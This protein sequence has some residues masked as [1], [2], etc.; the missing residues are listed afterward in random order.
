[1]EEIF[2]CL[3][4]PPIS[5]LKEGTELWFLDVVKGNIVVC[6]DTV[7]S[8]CVVSDIESNRHKESVVEYRIKNHTDRLIRSDEIGERYFLSRC[9]LSQVLGELV[10][11]TDP[12]ED[13]SA[14]YSILL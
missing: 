4:I 8:A 14:I 12:H 10:A 6:K 11:Q 5:V 7:V 3:R 1:M 2:F 9:D 13:L